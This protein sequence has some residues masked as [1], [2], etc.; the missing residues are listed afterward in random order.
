MSE[1]TFAPGEDI[2]RADFII[3]WVKSLGLYC[4]FESNFSDVSPESYYYE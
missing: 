4:E 1:T 2:K 3:L